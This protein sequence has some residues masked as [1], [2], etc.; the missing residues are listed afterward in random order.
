MISRAL[1]QMGQGSFSC[2]SIKKPTL[3]GYRAVRSGVPMPTEPVSAFSHLAGAVAMAAAGLLL[4]RRADPH[5]RR[6]PLAIFAVTAVV[7]LLASFTFHSMP[8]DTTAR[9]VAQR[10]DHAAIFTLIAGT[11]T[12]IQAILFRGML[13]WGMLSFIW[14]AAIAGLT[15]KVIFFDDVPEALGV[16]MYLALGWVGAISMAVIYRRSNARFVSPLVLGGLAY[17]V[18]AVCEFTGQPTIIAGIFGSHEMFHIAVLVGLGCHW[19]FI[20]RLTT[21]AP[22]HAVPE[23]LDRQQPLATMLESKPTG[24]ASNTITSHANASA[25]EQ[26]A[27][28]A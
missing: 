17:T 2:S 14:A 10:L 22:L 24:S 16:S 6:W 1:V 4:L 28:P 27:A 19:M 8:E 12:P 11:F 9:V 18:G 26:P 20:E 7:L 13:R 3:Y 15:L 5:W 23:Q 25:E 21:A